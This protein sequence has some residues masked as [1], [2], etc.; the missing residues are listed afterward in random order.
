MSDQE[1]YVGRLTRSM[2]SR[3]ANTTTTVTT[4]TATTH[5][6][7]RSSTLSLGVSPGGYGVT[8]GVSELTSGGHDPTFSTQ[9][10]TL[11][12][13]E[14]SPF[15]RSG[16]DSRLPSSGS[17]DFSS[18]SRYGVRQPLDT[19]LK[20]ES[21][22]SD[23][24]TTSD[25]ASVL[26]F[27]EK[28]QRDQERARQEQERARQ[29]ER[30]IQE[31]FRRE[32][33]RARQEERAEQERVR[34][35]ERAEQERV[36]REERAEMEARFYQMINA[37]RTNSQSSH[38][39][40][41]R[42]DRPRLKMPELKPGD[43]V[44]AFLEHFDTTANAYDMDEPTRI[45]Y[46]SA[47][48]SGKARDTLNAMP[49]GS[50]YGQLKDALRKR[51]RL[52]PETYR[53]KFRNMRKDADETFVQ[54]GERLKRTLN[55]WKTMAGMDLQDL[56]LIEQLKNSITDE[57][58]IH[59]TE[60]S[61]QSFD[62]AV[63][64]A[65]KFAEAR[66]SVKVMRNR[67][68]QN[69]DSKALRG[70]NDPARRQ[71]QNKALSAP[72]TSTSLEENARVNPQDR[73][74][75][76]CNQPGHI[77]RTCPLTRSKSQQQASDSS[78]KG[79]LTRAVPTTLCQGTAVEK[80]D[81]CPSLP[82]FLSVV[83]GR[84]RDAVRD[85]GATWV[86]VDESLVPEDA[87]RAGTCQVSG[88]QK[89]FQA[90]RPI[91]RVKLDTP[92]FEGEVWAVTLEKPPY[93]LV[94][95]NEVQFAGGQSCPVSYEL[96]VQAL[97]GVTTRAAAQ[98]EANALKPTRDPLQKG[99]ATKVDPQTVKNLQAKDPSLDSI[100]QEAL[101]EDTTATTGTQYVTKQGTLYRVFHKD[102]HRFRQL[103]VPKSLRPSILAMAHDTP[104]AGHLGSKRTQ[105]RVWQDFY[106]PGVSTDIRKYCRSC[107][108]CQRT[109]PK[110][111]NRRVPLGSVP[112]VGEPF[113]K[114]G[115]DL[116]GPIAP[117]SERG[118]RYILVMVDYA[119]RYPEAVALKSIDTCSVAE[120]LLQ[121]WTRVGIPTTVLS[122]MGTQF[123]SDL[124]KEIHQLLGIKGVSTS[125]YHAQAN[126][127]VE[128]FNGTLKQMLK[129]LCSEKPKDWDRLI[130][131]ILFAYREVPQESMQFSPFELLYG[132]TVRGPMSVLRR[133]WTEEDPGTEEQRTEAEY[134]VDLRNRLEMT[135]QIAKDHLK[136][137]SERYR[138]YYDKRARERWF[139]IGDE[140]LLLLPEKH[141]KLQM[142][143]QGP[144]TVTERVG[145][146]DYRVKIRGKERLYHANLLKAYVRRERCAAAV[147]PV[148]IEEEPPSEVQFQREGIPLIPLAAEETWSDVA[149][150][151]SLASSQ[152]DDLREMCRS[153]ESVLTDLPLKSTVGEC[154]LNMKS[155][156]PVLVRQYPL[157]HSQME[158]IKAEVQTMLKMGVIER[159]SSPYS[160]PIV[161]VRKKD[162][163]VRFCVD[164]RQ[165]NQN[166]KFDAEPIPNVDQIFA[167][168]GRAQYFSKLDLSKG[169]WQIPVKKEDRLKTA[170]TTPQGQFQWVTMPFGLKTAG[171]VFSRVMRRVLE[172]LRDP[173]VQNFM[174]DL[175]VATET[176]ETHTASLR[177]V[178]RRLAQ[179][180]MSARPT[181][182]RLGY[183]E[184]GFLGHTV[185]AGVLAPEEDKICKIR[186][187]TP[188]ETKRELRAFLGLAG[189][190]RR[191]VPRF[192]EIALP[193][194]NKTKG[195]EPQKV[196][197]S[198]E[199]QKAFAEMKKVLTS[200][201]V[202][203]LPDQN[204]PFVLRT[205]AS[206][207]GLGAVLLQERDGLLR[208]VAYAS[209]KL[210][211]AEQRYHTI[212]QECMAVVWGVRK[213]YPYLYGRHFLL[214]S[215]HNPLAYLHRIRP[216]SRRLMGWA[217]ELQSH[218][219][220]FRSI[221]GV[222]NLGADYLS[223][224]C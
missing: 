54:F 153:A 108:I 18:K 149:F 174:D 30:E 78:H 1:D 212:E 147:C 105:E 38:D 148:V 187:A 207:K 25:L 183:R 47:S 69:T 186:D 32:E 31:R 15:P 59:I 109:T 58:S 45:L 12:T 127:L 168:L 24:V 63:E 76:N 26:L 206:G 215:D 223:R 53:R 199:C 213:F 86:F 89:G 106:W 208:P 119:T 131:A 46:L 180:N 146:W 115:V 98:R 217:M 4:V 43:D 158:T 184:I 142:S 139:E 188:P 49:E 74:C 172:P 34:Q 138:Q 120:A 169:Y 117:A 61:P 128:R 222:D 202:L 214:E 141:N 44:D 65:D 2:T 36:R 60:G 185:S 165:L 96:P 133:L 17:R 209:K 27:M 71:E 118:H 21:A 204:E 57:L 100:R 64:R 144:Y 48:L 192:A 122:D 68:G 203:I 101:S 137:A 113:Q 121:M 35:E 126:G 20:T 81:T 125:P 155:D 107:D 93:S 62:E 56:I 198:Q 90:S 72:N 181:K 41:P 70:G 92:Y 159:S 80:R 189:Y 83:N 220:T 182:C 173:H 177:G 143:W 84:V 75:Y 200:E 22:R 157:P 7:T 145:D 132:R 160:A 191:F 5:S 140:V 40:R 156:K 79:L 14:H 216:V 103:V 102:G 211:E 151:P 179:V 167:G 10:K 123:V 87:E 104:M 195:R 150:G 33:E 52:T 73:T 161:L 154:E 94:I 97:A 3:Y 66:R 19:A 190:Y 9:R 50:S 13:P 135:C 23:L 67:T 16:L 8:G 85:T 176:W 114:V 129:R 99:I 166:L 112:L 77:R 136:K 152:K 201:P 164:Y 39:Q 28:T 224:S 130:P 11:F 134:V 196:V 42:M 210:N 51:F 163:A 170:F 95:G 205:D 175:M 82:M 91:V 193:L 171:A 110:G 162:G 111:H 55:Y 37:G 88:V 219:F 178:F 194:T 218:S 116:I 197:W 124:M 6:D 221:K 29:E